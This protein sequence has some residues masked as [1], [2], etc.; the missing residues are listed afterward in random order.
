[1]RIPKWLVIALLALSVV[2]IVG[3]LA[4]D[5]AVSTWLQQHPLT[6]GVISGTI[7]LPLTTLVALYLVDYFVAKS[8]QVKRAPLVAYLRGDVLDLTRRTL[9]RLSASSRGASGG[10]RN[11]ETE[12]RWLRHL[13]VNDII[14]DIN[15]NDDNFP[16][17]PRNWEPLRPSEMVAG[18][19]VRDTFSDRSF[20]GLYFASRNLSAAIHRLASETNDSDLLHVAR[21]LDD[22]LFQGIEDV[23]HPRVKL[24]GTRNSPA[25]LSLYSRWMGAEIL[26]SMLIALDLATPDDFVG[27]YLLQPSRAAPHGLGDFWMPTSHT[28]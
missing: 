27:S 13:V 23:A 16:T 4:L 24:A 17:L 11:L 18:L 7:A 6:A 10:A 25:G 8:N 5:E 19:D 1:L 22:E 15:A 21:L 3:A 26:M 12:V 28:A 9:F 2:C 20:E 14:F